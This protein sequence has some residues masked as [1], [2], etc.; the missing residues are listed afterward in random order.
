MDNKE[1]Q[2]AFELLSILY[3]LSEEKQKEIY[4]VTE[5]AK[6]IANREESA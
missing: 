1:R 4:Y 5:G 3:K 6:F 2:E